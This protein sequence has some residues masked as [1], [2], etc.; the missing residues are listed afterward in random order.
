MKAQFRLNTENMHNVSESQFILTCGR[1][2]GEVITGGFLSEDR[3]GSVLLF[4]FGGFRLDEALLL[5]HFLLLPPQILLLYQLP[6]C[7]L[8]LL[9][10]ALLFGLPS[11]EKSDT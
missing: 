4:G 5:E 2:L 10:Q 6:S 7:F 9:T 8:L 1:A 11:N 3:L